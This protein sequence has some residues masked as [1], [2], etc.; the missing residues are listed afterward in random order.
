MRVDKIKIINEMRGDIVV[1][2]SVT[3]FIEKTVSLQKEIDLKGLMEEIS[4]VEGWAKVEEL[5]IKIRK[6]ED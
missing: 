4:K 5:I 2:V 3:A 1:Q 6:K